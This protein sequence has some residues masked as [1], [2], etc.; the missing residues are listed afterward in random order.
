MGARILAL[1]ALLVAL[2]SWAQQPLKVYAA[3]SLKGAFQD[4]AAEYQSRT[5]TPV[6]LELGPSGLLRDRLATGEPGDVFA[7]ANM[8]HPRALAEKG[9]AGPPVRFARNQLCALVAPAVSVA[10]GTLLERML[11]PAVKLGTS[12]PKSDP[13]GDYAWELFRRADRLKPGAYERLSGKALMLT[14]GPTSPTAPK[15]HSIYAMLVSGG[16]ADIF[17]TYC[18]NALAARNEVQDLRMV[19]VPRDL[20][21]GADYGIAVLNAGSRRGAD[22]VGFLL[23]PAGQQVLTRHGFASAEEASR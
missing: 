1:F 19:S 22:F 18:T 23:S 11:D 12:T 4:L 5:G 20:A 8:E 14:G 13:S 3:G 7:S 9:L 10:E 16:Q 15:D 17:L 21:V 6:V 2:P